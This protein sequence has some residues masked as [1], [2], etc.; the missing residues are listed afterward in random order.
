[1]DRNGVIHDTLKEFGY[2][3]TN[4]IR[5]DPAHGLTNKNVVGME[6]I[7]KHDWDVLPEQVKAAAEFMRKYYPNT[8]VYGHGQVN[9]D[10]EPDEGQSA[11]LAVE[12]DRKRMRGFAGMHDTA[13]SPHE[14]PHRPVSPTPNNHMGNMAH[15]QQDKGMKVHVSNPAGSN[16]VV[17]SAMLGN[18]SGSYGS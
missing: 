13:A 16:V 4:E 2:G 12:A 10:K 11:R 3:G 18:G 8:P 14:M 9:P 6:I 1:M 17:Q 7:A 15:F 5:N